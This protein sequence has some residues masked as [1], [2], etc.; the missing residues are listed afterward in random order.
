MKFDSAT[1]T[2]PATAVLPGSPSARVVALLRRSLVLACTCIALSGCIN[3]IPVSVTNHSRATLSNAVVSGSGFSESLGTISPG[4][5][6]TVR[7]RPRGQ[8]QVKIAF[9]VD[10]QRYSS[11]TVDYIENDEVHGLRVGVDADFTISIET[12]ER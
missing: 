11:T 3:G 9:E 6:E 2:T 4:G 5:T 1:A 7:V 8:T 10:G 12:S